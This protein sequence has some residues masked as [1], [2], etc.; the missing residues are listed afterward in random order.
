MTNMDESMYVCVWQR[1]RKRK[2]RIKSFEW[3]TDRADFRNDR[4]LNVWEMFTK[5]ISQKKNVTPT[6]I[7]TLEVTATAT[8]ITTTAITKI[9]I[10][11]LI[12]KEN[13]NEIVMECIKSIL[14]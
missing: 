9:S 4:Q 8:V 12:R 11:T 1:K 5:N 3:Q 13:K 10:Q 2:T 14:I 6:V 7:A